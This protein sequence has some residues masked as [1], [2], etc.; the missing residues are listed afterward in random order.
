MTRALSDA[1]FNRVAAVFLLN[2]VSYT[3]NG[4]IEYQKYFIP[5]EGAS[6]GLPDA[7][8]EGLLAG[9][10]DPQGPRWSRH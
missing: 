2:P 10:Q 3:G 9:N 1:R 6:R 7:V 8:R 5:N 4:V